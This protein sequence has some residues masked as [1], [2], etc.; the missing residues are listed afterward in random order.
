MCWIT[1][2]SSGIGEALAKMLYNRGARVILS[3][4]SEQKLE[5]ICSSWDD[6]ERFMILPL[7]MSDHDS[8]EQAAET[9][10]RKWKR[11]DLLVNNAGVS[12]RSLAAE[13][14]FS[15]MKQII[16]INYL[17][18]AGL[19]RE[20]L[21]FMIKQGSGIIAPVSSVA[22]KFATPLRSSYSASKM[23]LQGYFDG[24]RAE[25]HE[26]GIQINLIVPGFVRTNISLNAMNAT[27]GKHG[28]M[29]P[30]Q[31]SGIS[32]EAAA[33]IILKGLEKNKREIYMGI[34]PKVKLALFLS[35]FLPSVLARML[36]T[37]E[38]K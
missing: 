20:V 14:D 21:P 36:R 25:V 28:E 22:G 35:R 29:D 4:R 3:A 34:A 1:G 9:A 5:E 8:L 27:G 10:C 30:N 16:D 33:E 19:T 11:L 2:A 24:L 23:A 6:K 26:K 13:T 32:P 18:A 31:D 38:V 12:Q 37:A 15:V 7:D 17:G